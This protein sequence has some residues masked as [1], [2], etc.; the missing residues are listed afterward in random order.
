MGYSEII[1]DC[2]NNWFSDIES[3]L[4]DL[5]EKE[6]PELSDEDFAEMFVVEFHLDSNHPYALIRLKTPEELL[7]EYKKI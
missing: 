6:C 4:R 5:K 1:N 7:E 2:I 3:Y